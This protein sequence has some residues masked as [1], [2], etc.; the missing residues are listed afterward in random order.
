MA[1]PVAR[2]ARRGRRHVAGPAQLAAVRGRQQPG[3][4]GDPEGR[5]EVL[6]RPRRSSLDSPKPTTPR[7]GVLRGQPGQRAGVQ[8]VPGAVR[9]DDHPDPEPGRPA[10]SP[11]RPGPPRRRGQPTQPGRVRRGVHLDL[12]PAGALARSSSAASRTSRWMS[13][14]LAEA[15]SGRRRRAAGSGTSRARRSPAARRGAVRSARTSGRRTPYSSASSSRVAGRIDP[16]KCRCR[17]AFGS[18]RRSRAPEAL[19][20]L[21]VLRPAASAGG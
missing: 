21:S 4:L 11:P 13:S 18:A 10:A 3:P 5:G 12:Q 16:V 15:P 2:R 14:A 9:R 6:G 1:D 7:S 17:W 19:A 8:R 20:A